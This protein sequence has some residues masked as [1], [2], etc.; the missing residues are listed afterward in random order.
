MIIKQVFNDYIALYNILN[1][2]KE[3]NET[4]VQTYFVNE[5][6]KREDKSVK[7][8]VSIIEIMIPLLI[9]ITVT[10]IAIL[11]FKS[12]FITKFIIGLIWLLCGF[13]LEIVVLMTN[14]RIINK[15]I[16]S[17]EKVTH[18]A[19]KVVL[20]GKFLLELIMICAHMSYLIL[21]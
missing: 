1:K 17:K 4:E 3:D 6:L 8:L 7:Y 11:M 9:F 10:I 12:D 15:K 13:F 5:I 16:Q 21:K 19:E 2:T 14:V 18:V 20:I